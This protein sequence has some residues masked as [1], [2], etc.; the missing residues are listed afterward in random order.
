M[1]R[2]ITHTREVTDEIQVETRP[3]DARVFV[4]MADQQMYALTKE[5]ASG[6][7]DALAVAA[8]ELEGR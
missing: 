4:R 5:Q 6:L 1:I 8:N 2:H 3:N 7:R